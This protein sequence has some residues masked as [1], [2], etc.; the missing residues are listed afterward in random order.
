MWNLWLTGLLSFLL[1][2]NPTDAVECH[3]CLSYCKILPDGQLDIESCDCVGN[4]TCS[5]ENCFAKVELFNSESVAIVQK[6]CAENQPSGPTGCYYAGQPESI[7]CYCDSDK[8]NNRKNLNDYAPQRLPIVECCECSTPNGEKCPDD[9]CARTCRGNYC[10]IDFDGLEQGC[11]VGL[12]R[13]KNFL[14]IQNY[15]DLQGTATCANYLATE[16][17]RVHGCVCTSP[18]GH[19]NQINQSRAYEEEKVN[20]RRIGDSNYC[21]SLHQKSKK[22]FDEEVFRKSETCQGHYCFISLTSSELVI[23]NETNGNQTDVQSSF[24]G[25][26]RPRFEILAGCIQADDDRKVSVGCTTEFSLNSSEPISRHC[27]CDSH[28][29]NT[30]G[31]VTN[32]ETNGKQLLLDR[33]HDHEDVQPSGESTPIRPSEA[34]ATTTESSG[35]CIRKRVGIVLTLFNLIV[36]MM[37]S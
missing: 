28:L 33:S 7:H 4:Q 12:P 3:S 25:I 27:I 30:F 6:G 31:M 29:C 21:Y 11:G 36:A 13:L 20:A 15:S 1:T 14:R 2:A 32:E 37:L 24:V 18:T 9:K 5:A 19:C 35:N 23:E 10:L 22:P 17:T 26:A 8:C 16:S 34:S